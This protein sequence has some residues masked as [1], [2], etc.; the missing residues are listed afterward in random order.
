[1]M[2]APIAN[3]VI[4]VADAGDL[5]ARLRHRRP[6][7]AGG[8]SPPGRRRCWAS[9]RRSASSVQLLIL[10]PYL[11][12]AGVTFRPRFDFR[13][14]GLGH[15][16]RLGVWT[17][18][19]VWSTR[20]PTP[21]WSGSPRAAPAGRHDPD[22]TGYTVYSA[23]FLIMMVPHS[24]VTV[25]L[26][27]AMLPRLSRRADGR[28]LGG[29]GRARWRARCAPRWSWSS[30]SPLLLPWSSRRPGPRDLR[31]RRRPRRT[32]RTR[33]VARAVRRRAGLLHR[34]LPDAARLLRPR[35][36]PHR[37]RRS[38]ASSPPINIAGR[39]AAG[40]ATDDREHLAGPGRRLHRAYLVGAVVSSL[41]AARA[42]SA[43]SATAGAGCGVRSV[44]LLLA[45][46]R[47]RR[48]VASPCGCCCPTCPTTRSGA[49]AS[50]TLAR[51]RRASRCWSFLVAGPAAAANEVTS[52]LDMV[53]RRHRQ[54][55]VTAL[56]CTGAARDLR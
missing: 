53:L 6:A 48:R 4:A 16:L 24:V 52:V 56:R 27:T 25:S 55:A 5:P 34:P 31:L 42:G 35:A 39:G 37:V 19:F 26:A 9:A 43:G 14:T 10:V 32:S 12:A 47:R 20:S 44:R 36:D 21:S 46:G 29:L 45:V 28:D 51:A 17:V 13:G 11:A 40:R 22:G 33:A 7:R 41:V 3:N 1:M 50:P 30:R 18:L 49:R 2:W 38:S 8:R 15:T 54:R 23:T